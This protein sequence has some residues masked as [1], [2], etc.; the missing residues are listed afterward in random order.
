MIQDRYWDEGWMTIEAKTLR[1]MGGCDNDTMHLQ[2]FPYCTPEFSLLLE[3]SWP[4]MK[5]I[6]KG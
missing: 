3:A 4:C 6:V 2:L 1:M 5:N